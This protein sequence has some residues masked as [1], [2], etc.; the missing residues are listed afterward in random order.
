MPPNCGLRHRRR[1]RY[2]ETPRGR[3]S[4]DLREAGR[5]RSRRG[6]DGRTCFPGRMPSISVGSRSRER[7]SCLDATDGGGSGP[8]RMRADRFRSNPGLRSHYESND[9]RFRGI[10]FTP[11][12]TYAAEPRSS[13]GP[14]RHIGRPTTPYLAGGLVTIKTARRQ[15]SSGHRDVQAN[16]RLTGLRYPTSRFLLF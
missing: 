12:L 11:F 3:R 7:R 14:R 4:A 16:S 2:V 5:H 13:F 15:G 1:R 9:P 10:S 6:R 8:K